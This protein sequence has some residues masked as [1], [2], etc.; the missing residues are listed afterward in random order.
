MLFVGLSIDAEM[1]L[2]KPFLAHHGLL[3]WVLILMHC[4][5]FYLFWVQYVSRSFYDNISVLRS[6]SFQFD[7]SWTLC[8]RIMPSIL[9][10][11]VWLKFIKTSMRWRYWAS[12][13]FNYL[14]ILVQFIF[15]K[16]W[17]WRI[18]CPSLGMVLAQ[19]L[20]AFLVKCRSHV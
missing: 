9:G 14:F 18:T 19:I 4:P 5:S 2:H 17:F 1:A 10:N 13:L 11:I 12:C 15:Q 7:W 20:W 3:E 6:F 16:S 8:H